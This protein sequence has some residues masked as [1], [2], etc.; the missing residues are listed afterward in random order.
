MMGWLLKKLVEHHKLQNQNGN[1]DIEKKE[2]TTEST[3]NQWISISNKFCNNEYCKTIALGEPCDRIIPDRGLKDQLCLFEFVIRIGAIIIYEMIQALKY[4][5]LPVLENQ[6]NKDILAWKWVDNVIK[7]DLILKAF[8]ELEPV[9]RM[10]KRNKNDEQPKG[11]FYE[12]DKKDDLEQIARSFQ[13]IFPEV[14]ERLEDII[15]DIPGEV[16]WIR[17][18]ANIRRL[19]KEEQ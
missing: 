6:I 4:G 8:A 11:P 16:E 12:V 7:P 15:K 2:Q 3:L 9:G 14:Y 10:L 17:N 18:Y 13:G 5:S 1:S 19:E